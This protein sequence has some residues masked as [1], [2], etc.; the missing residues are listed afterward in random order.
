MEE[1]DDV[2]YRLTPEGIAMALDIHNMYLAGF[3]VEQIADELAI[4]V[5][6]VQI[7]FAM[8]NLMGVFDND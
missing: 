8:A 1:E 4:E 3:D 6:G 5:K 2:R 7:I